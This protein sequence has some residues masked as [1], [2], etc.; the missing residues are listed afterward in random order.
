M[1]RS[2][3][4]ESSNKTLDHTVCKKVFCLT[5]SDAPGGINFK[6]SKAKKQSKLKPTPKIREKSKNI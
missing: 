6:A 1:F 4:L 3:F 2:C 5:F